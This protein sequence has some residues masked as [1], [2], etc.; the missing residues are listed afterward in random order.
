MLRAIFGEPPRQD[1]GLLLE[2]NEAIRGYLRTVTRTKKGAAPTPQERRYAIW[3]QSFLRALDEMEQSQYAAARYGERVKTAFVDRMER[4]E[5]DDYHRHLYYYNNAL[6]RLFAVLDKLGHFMNER[7]ALKTEKIKSRF[8]YFTVL[9]NMHQHKL[10]T[11]LEE[12]LY[13]LKTSYKEPLTRL[14][15]QRNMEI[16]T[17][18]ADLLDDLMK[19]EEAKYGERPSSETED[20]RGNLADLEQGCDMAFRSVTTVFR[21]LVR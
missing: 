6:I 3:C 7:L 15:N 2:A 10:F 21:Y 19:A 12:K 16:H 8:S 11:D 1:S 9:R 20:V 4:E 18:N 14:R 17:I 5:L 13:E